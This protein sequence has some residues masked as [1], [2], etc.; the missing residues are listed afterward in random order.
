MTINKFNIIKEPWSKC[1]DVLIGSVEGNLPESKSIIDFLSEINFMEDKKLTHQGEEYYKQKYIFK[2]KEKSRDILSE[3]LKKYEPVQLI[4][5][6]LWGKDNLTKES[7]YNLLLLKKYINHDFKPSDLGSFLMLLNQCRIIKYSKKY[8]KIAIRYNPKIDNRDITSKRFLS[9]QTPYTNIKSL[10]DTLRDCNDYIWWFDK[11]FSKKGLEPL[12][13]AVDG[14]KIREI[15]ILTG[16]TNNI[17]D[18]F[19][20]DY[21]RFQKEME[22]KGIKLEMR[23]ICDKNIL[24]KIHDRW[25]ISKNRC[26]KVPP[27]NS[28]YQNQYSEINTTVNKPPFNDWWKNGYDI[29]KKWSEIERELTKK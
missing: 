22:N 29:L 14:K 6:L 15:K 20:K 21:Y 5:Q 27:I 11:H 2:D 9:P 16:L 3:V 24:Q 1:E 19:K 13:E 28:I 8:D 25:I 23:V 26:F 12:S 10:W 17:H 4:C 7:I 18:K